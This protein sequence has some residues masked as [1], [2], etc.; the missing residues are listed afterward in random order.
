MLRLQ[1]GEYVMERH[2]NPDGKLSRKADGPFRFLR[3]TDPDQTVCML[4]DSEQ[5]QWRTSVQRVRR[6]VSR[7]QQQQPP[8]QQ[9]QAD[10][11]SP[12]GAAAAAAAATTA[13]AA[14]PST[15]PGAAGPSR[16]PRRGAGAPS[17]A[18]VIII[19]SSDTDPTCADGNSSDSDSL[20]PGPSEALP[21]AEPPRTRRQSARA[22][23]L[24]EEEEY[25]MTFRESL[26][27]PPGRPTP[28]CTAPKK[29][30]RPPNGEGPAVKARR[31]PFNGAPSDRVSRICGGSRPL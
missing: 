26:E 7:K 2:E 16:M 31:L 30:G 24:Q 27:T 12:A 4:E 15:N 18:P 21:A 9:Q 29:R 17:R 25:K 13:D 11:P 10:T 20:L 19:T 14:G 22:K 8:Q 3:Y 23:A 1:E 6:W 28:G 5:R